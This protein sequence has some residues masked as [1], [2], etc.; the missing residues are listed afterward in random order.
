MNIGPNIE[1]AFYSYNLEVFL[2]RN[3]SGSVVEHPEHSS[4]Y[5]A[6]IFKK[7][8]RYSFNMFLMDT[9]CAL[10]LVFVAIKA[11]MNNSFCCN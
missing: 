2:E 4:K 7:T 11:K 5:I 6:Y 9:F 1:R 3:H 8:T 10:I